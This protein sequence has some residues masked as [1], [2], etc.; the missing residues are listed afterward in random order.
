MFSKTVIFH[1]FGAQ[2]VG[3]HLSLELFSFFFIFKGL[4]MIIIPMMT[5]M[6][7]PQ[8]ASK[9]LFLGLIIN[10]LLD[11]ILVPLFSYMGATFSTGIAQIVMTFLLI[12]M[13]RKLQPFDFSVIQNVKV[14]L[15][16]V[17]FF[18]SVLVM[19]GLIPIASIKSEMIVILA[20][21]GVFAVGFALYFL[22]LILTKVL[23]K[24]KFKLLKSFFKG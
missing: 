6:G 19:K 17:A 2:Y 14:I 12:R 16:G 11:L 22:L 1:I 21:A 20:G 4:N 15:S 9:I 8:K 5:A 18:V 10:T 3:A 13:L 24:E 23:T 7:K